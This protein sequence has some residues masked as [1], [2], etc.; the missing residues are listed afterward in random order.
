MKLDETK[1]KEYTKRLLLARLRILNDHTFYGLLLMTT[2]FGLDENAGTAYTDGNRICF[3]PEFM[4]KLNNQELDFIL[5]HEIMHIVL[6]HC[7]RTGKRDNDLFNIATD[8]VVN[9][10]ILKSNNMNLNT[11]IADNKVGMHLAPNGDE[12]FNYTAEEIYEMLLT[13]S[14]LK[15]T[16]KINGIGCDLS[17]KE[18]NEWLKGILID[19]HDNWSLSKEEIEKIDE[20]I[21]S[22]VNTMSNSTKPGDIPAGVLRE[23][24]KLTKPQ[25][26][27]RQVLK[28][29]LSFEKF[30]YSFTPPDKRYDEFF[31]P[32]FNEVEEKLRINLLIAIDTSGSMEKKD[33]TLAMSEIKSI[34]DLSN[35]EAIGQ[36]VCFDAKIYDP[37]PIEDFDIEK[38]KLK[39]GGGTS[40]INLFKALD[41]LIDNNLCEF[42]AIIIF[43]D[44]YSDFPKEEARKDIPVLWIINNDDVT[45]PWGMIAR[46]S[47]K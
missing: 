27:W 3:D 42:D 39:G 10:N 6:K 2:K 29:F 9:S 35:G 12:G 37:I 24:N 38:I 7:A 40:F 25:L 13:P 28:D 30:D 15:K 22:I 14:N 16:L 1:A 43:T 4:D 41:E 8:I 17:N 21:V 34:L 5:M 11:I 32:D 19:R 44:G 20:K 18:L 47:R 26:D 45:P 23:F 46:I 33:L 36:I 31:M